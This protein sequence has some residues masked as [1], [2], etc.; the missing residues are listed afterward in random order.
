M[1]TKYATAPAFYKVGK[2]DS[3][4]VDGKTPVPLSK[5]SPP[6]SKPLIQ[7]STVQSAK[8]LLLAMFALGAD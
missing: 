4:D 1:T 8:I 5:Y 6:N 7:I 2:Y 3:G